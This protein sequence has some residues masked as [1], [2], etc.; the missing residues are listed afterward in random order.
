MK[1]S[2]KL[3]FIII[4]LIS[5][6][7][8]SQTS[9][10]NIYV[11]YFSG[12]K[13]NINDLTKDKTIILNFWATWCV[14]CINE[15]NNINE[16]Y[17]EWQNETNVILLAISIDDSRSISRVMPLSR[18]NNWSFEILFDKNQELKRALNIANIPY[19]M[20]IHNGVIIYRHAGYVNGQEN[21]L[22]KKIKEHLGID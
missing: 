4:L 18:S 7:C 21:I 1:I 3:M 10:P 5:N 9:L 8:Y 20:A 16:V 13:V 14:P 6:Y 15:L 11:D 19:Q 22:I 12:E 2:R 17:S